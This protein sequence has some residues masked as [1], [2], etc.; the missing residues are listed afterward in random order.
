MPQ[1]KESDCAWP[2]PVGTAG[3]AWT[4]KQKLEWESRWSPQRSYKEEVLGKLD[5]FKKS[6]PNFDE[7][8]EVVKYGFLSVNPKRYPLMAVKPRAGTF[9]KT[10][11]TVLFTGGVHGYETSGVQGALLFLEKHAVE[12][13]KRFN[14][15][16]APCVSPWGYEHIQRWTWKAVDPNRSFSRTDQT[17]QTEE[18][19]ALMKFI[20]DIVGPSQQDDE[21]PRSPG[22]S[23]KKMKSS[24]PSS[25]TSTRSC[26][27]VDTCST[28]AAARS[29]IPID[30][31]IDLHETT[32][33]DATEFRPAKAARDGNAFVFER[34]GQIPYGFYLVMDS[35][36][37]AGRD[38]TNPGKIPS[39]KKLTEGERIAA[40]LSSSSTDGADLQIKAVVPKDHP[41]QKKFYMSMLKEVKKI[42]HVCTD[43]AILGF[44]CV[45][46]GGAVPIPVKSL[47]L[48]QALTDAPYTTTTEV[49]PDAEGVTGEICNKAQVACIVG[50]LEFLTK[51]GGEGNPPASPKAGSSPMKSNSPKRRKIE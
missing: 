21:P 41:L 7:L 22:T 8:F 11:K 38:V 39:G 49:Y 32:D 26:K 14:I 16:C 4:D 31:H 35:V 2:Y 45:E 1:P 27:K 17:V 46:E 33:T 37:C 50:A 42:T 34:D 9:C 40:G 13:S 43:D 25:P 44:A 10:K 48:C 36:Y 28:G 51:L 3:K 23:S 30:L 18:S 5:K 19:V 47:N 6:V 20:D 24:C 15:I 12:Y 29:M